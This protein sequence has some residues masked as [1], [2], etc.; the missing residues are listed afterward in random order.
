[1]TQLYAERIS[2]IEA[3]IREALQANSS[4]YPP[5]THPSPLAADSQSDLPASDSV[6]VYS[7]RASRA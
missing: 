6:L 4:P 1:L 5:S 3:E 2:R 7:P